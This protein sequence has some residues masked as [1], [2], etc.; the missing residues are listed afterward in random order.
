MVYPTLSG[1][2]ECFLW[3]KRAAEN[4][5]PT[6]AFLTHSASSLT[7]DG[8]QALTCRRGNLSATSRD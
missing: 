8:W 1:S 5:L 3:R 4:F 2:L 7:M 6:V